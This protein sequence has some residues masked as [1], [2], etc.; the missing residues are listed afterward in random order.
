MDQSK[1]DELYSRQATRLPKGNQRNRQI[2]RPSAGS[3]RFTRQEET[4]D[5]KVVRREFV[6][7]WPEIY[8]TGMQNKL[9]GVLRGILTDKIIISAATG[10]GKTF[11]SIHELGL[12]N[13][14]TGVKC[15]VAM[16]YRIERLKKQLRKRHVTNHEVT[17][18]D[19]KIGF[20]N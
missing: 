3:A 17:L 1:I 11:M 10:Q 18:L 12:A 4:N 5:K 20:R 19:W 15:V 9:K 14:E 2:Q 8:K 6:R 7:I 16:P 13:Q